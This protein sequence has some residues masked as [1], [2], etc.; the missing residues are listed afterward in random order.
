M[1]QP[2]SPLT[3]LL[4]RHTRRLAFSTLLVSV[5]AA[6]GPPPVSGQQAPTPVVGVLSSQ[7]QDSEAAVL[8]AWH[9]G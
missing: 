8:A 7:S 5:A 4:S 2:P 3:M 9:G 6:A 1:T